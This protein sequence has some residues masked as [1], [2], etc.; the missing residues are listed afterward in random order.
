M[1]FNIQNQIELKFSIDLINNF[2]LKTKF[3]NSSLLFKYL[4]ENI[5]YA[6]KKLSKLIDCNIFHIDFEFLQK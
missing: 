4:K 1:H 3:S 2:R 5:I 6:E